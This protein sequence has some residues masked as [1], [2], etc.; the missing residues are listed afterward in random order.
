MSKLSYSA[1]MGEQPAHLT[2]K[3]DTAEPIELEDFVGAFTSLA[4]EFE[5]FVS[6]T[7]P[8]A[9]ADPRIYLREVRSGC[10]EADMITGLM[11]AAGVVIN[12]MDQILILE[13]F[14]K[15]WGK[16][17]TAL[18]ANKVPEGELETTTQLQDYYRAAES[19]SSDPI[20]THRL[21]ATAFEKDGPRVRVAFEFTAVEARTAQQN[22]EDRKKLLAKPTA[23]PR[24]RVMM[25]Y[26]RTDVHDAALNKKSAERVLIAELSD[27]ELAV[28]YASEL[29]EQEI[30]EIIREA[31]ENVY[32]KRF[33]VDV[34]EQMEGDK[35]V[36]YSVTALHSVIQIED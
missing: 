33:V 8:G 15:R 18:I 28:M 13:D 9:K 29:V 20:A 27:K 24:P 36:A 10:V 30:R 32:K 4:N 14:V 25:R 23:T 7:Y 6:E 19:I 2:L 34:M 35:L 17:M 5:R 1:I 16:R 31:A 12:H 11:I 26:T 3:L 21:S 22:I